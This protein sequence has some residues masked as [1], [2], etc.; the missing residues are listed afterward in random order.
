MIMWALLLFAGIIAVPLVI[1]ALRKPMTDRMRKNA[2]GQFAELSQGK[3]HF[4][5]FGPQDGPVVLCIHGLTTPSFVWNG[6]APLLADHGMRVL[7]YDI[8]GRG[9]SDRVPGDQDTAFFIRQ[10]NDLLEHE[11]IDDDLTVIGYSMGGAVATA[12]A[13]RQPVGIRNLVLLAPAGMKTVASGTTRFLISV[14]IFGFWLM[15]LLYPS[16]LR[17][18]LRKEATLETSVP[19]INRMQNEELDY[20]GFLPSVFMSLRGILKGQMD[21]QH[22]A[23]KDAD[24]PVLAVWGSED[25]I[26]PLDAKNVL[27]GWNSNVEHV[28]LPDAGHG[29]TYTHTAEVF[30]AIRSFA[31]ATS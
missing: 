21:A 30:E 10:V 29:L 23:I 13:A 31:T 7:T 5:W 11:K 22:R 14:P 12:Y 3:T 16:I 2:P 28:V 26:I 25:A 27:S 18:G 9:Y 4:R 20:R 8:Y 1:E 15:L 17:G 19:D 6:L 24:L